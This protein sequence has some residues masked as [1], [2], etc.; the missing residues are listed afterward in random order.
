MDNTAFYN[1]ILNN[2]ET[3]EDV[4]KFYNM[5]Q[6]YSDIYKDI[7]GIRPRSESSMCVN[8]YS[9]TPDL[10]KFRELL[11]NGINPLASVYDTP[12]DCEDDYI[13]YQDDYEEDFLNDEEEHRLMDGHSSKEQILSKHPE[14]EQYFV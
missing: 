5:C 4:Q 8:A 7:Y 10:E 14:Y 3:A 9:G 13:D 2:Q 11:K 1:R 12:D 6:D